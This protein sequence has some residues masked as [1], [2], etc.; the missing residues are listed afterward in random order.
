[1]SSH[2]AKTAA[3]SAQALSKSPLIQKAASHSS[4][5]STP[6]I[7]SRSTTP[8]SA[9]AA[10]KSFTCCSVPNNTSSSSPFVQ[11]QKSHFSTHAARMASTMPAQHGHN[12]ACCNI[13]P[14]ISKGYEAK[15]AYEEIG[16][17]KTYVTG[18]ADAKKAIVVIY[19]IFGF[20]PQTLQGADILATSDAQKYRVFIPDWFAGE[21]CPIEWF[22][23]NTE[24]K[25]K[26][27]GG[28]FQKFPPPKVAGQVPDYVKAVQDKYSSLESFGILG[29]C[30]GGKVVSL[31]ASGDSNPF[32]IGAE[33]HPAM[34]EPEDAKGIKIPLILLAS[35]EEPDDA[36]KQFEGNL[37]AAKHVETFKDQIH[38]WMAARSDLEDA[39]VKE[40]YSR[41]YKTVLQFFGKNF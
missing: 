31:V 20:F 11:T 24:E 28:F 4:S 1:M 6:V 12:E 3:R 2:T 27:V 40:E 13:P 33:I 30:W 10:S 17:F 35:K 22:P 15:G 36:V 41:G 21:P 16:G 8:A 37:T 5:S 29:Y 34:V 23:P 26:N 32:K 7:A 25:Q 39:R 14:V 38:G 19:D 18:P 9:T